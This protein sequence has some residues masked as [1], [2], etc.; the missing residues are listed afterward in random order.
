MRD[1]IGSKSV[2]EP[3]EVSESSIFKRWHKE[4]IDENFESQLTP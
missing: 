2:S 3:K 1:Y 4:Y